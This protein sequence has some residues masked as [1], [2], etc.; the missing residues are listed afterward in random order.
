MD[1]LLLFVK[2]PRSGQ[3]KTRLAA[4]VGAAL[5]ADLYRALVRRVL[6]A[7]DGAAERVVLVSPADAVDE[8][9]TWLAGEKCVAQDGADLG[10]RMANAFQAAFAL[11][12]RRAAVAGSD[13]PALDAARVQEAFAALATSD[14]AIAPAGDGGYSLLALRAPQPQ[15]FADM[16]WS[17]PAVLEETLRRAAGLRVTVLPELRDLDTPNDLRRE[18]PALQ[19]ILDADLRARI[20]DLLT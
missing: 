1:M 13:V 16:E 4:L 14:V 19:R 2:A 7:T 6:R 9:S 11:G 15:L 20:A 18:W 3:V 10:A 8:V 5:A 12:A 17:T